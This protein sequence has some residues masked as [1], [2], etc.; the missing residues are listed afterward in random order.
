MNIPCSLLRLK[1]LFNIL[2][3]SDSHFDFLMHNTFE[4]LVGCFNH[5]EWPLAKT[6]GEIDFVMSKM[7]TKL[8]VYLKVKL[9]K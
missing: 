5:C 2:T 6:N 7:E 9:Q 8:K 3:F 1:R 4:N